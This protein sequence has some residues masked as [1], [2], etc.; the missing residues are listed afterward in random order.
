MAGPVLALVEFA[1]PHAELLGCDEVFPV[2][3]LTPRPGVDLGLLLVVLAAAAKPAEDRFFV[4]GGRITVLR[5][6]AF[7]A[8]LVGAA[9]YVRGQ[10]VVVGNGPA[11]GGV[12][13]L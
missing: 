2:R 7:E 10:Q 1:A 6:E 4:S 3:R 8:T 11:T 12:H 13:I 9:G 5:P